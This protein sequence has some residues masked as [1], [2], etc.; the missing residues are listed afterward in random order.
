MAIPW[1]SLIDVAFGLTDVV[2]RVRGGA[3]SSPPR[4]QLASATPARAVRDTRLAGVMMS[5]LREAFDRDHQRHELE[6]QRAE[7]ERL[8]AEEER[9]RAERAMR[10]ELLR[11]SGD[12]EMGRMRTVLIASTVSLLGAILFATRLAAGTGVR[13]TLGF[14]LLLLL[15]AVAQSF[16]EQGRVARLLASADDRLNPDRLTSIN[17]GLALGSMLVGLALIGIAVLSA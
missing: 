3:G 15:A 4:S 7:E 5:A 10:L 12:R 14:G 2:R 17:A 6:R 16:A 9:L 11:Q 13:V 8:R 1:I